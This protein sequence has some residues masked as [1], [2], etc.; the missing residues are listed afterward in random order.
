MLGCGGLHG[1][2]SKNA[3]AT[4]NDCNPGRV[5]MEGVCSTPMISGGGDAAGDQAEDHEADSGSADGTVTM[6]D[7][8]DM[9]VATDPKSSGTPSRTAVARQMLGKWKV[10]SPGNGTTPEEGRLGWLAGPSGQ[11]QLTAT[12]W[13]PLIDAP[14]AGGGTV[15]VAGGVGGVYYFLVEATSPVIHIGDGSELAADAAVAASVAAGVPVL[16]FTSCDG[17]DVC[18]G[19][20]TRLVAVPATAGAAPERQTTERDIDAT[21]P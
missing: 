14:G 8:C 13:L 21:A 9:A 2:E 5:C 1:L 18:A 19:A 15:P 17:T 6:V 4:S 16:T 20:V 12:S 11:V 3:C 7:P 10:C